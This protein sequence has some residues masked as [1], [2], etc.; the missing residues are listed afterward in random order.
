MIKTKQEIT[1][2]LEYLTRMFDA[3]PKSK[4]MGYIGELNDISLF[5]EVARRTAKSNRSIP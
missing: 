2:L 3:I 1:L 4:R 5:L